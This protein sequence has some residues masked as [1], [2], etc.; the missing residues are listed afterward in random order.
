[1]ATTALILVTLA[2]AA[3]Q[4]PA[5]CVPI[6]PALGCYSDT[7]GPHVVS[8]YS[9]GP[10]SKMTLELCTSICDDAGFTLLGLTGTLTPTPVAECYCGNTPD[11]KAVPAPIAECGDPCPGNSAE[12]CGGNYR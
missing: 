10:S 7:A 3:A 9:T 12:L 11:P 1:M 2:L 5:P 6:T 4:P 8:A